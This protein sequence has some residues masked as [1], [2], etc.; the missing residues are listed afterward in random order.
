MLGDFNARIGRNYKSWNKVI[1]RH[2]VGKENR[3][4]TMLLDMC[5]RHK[6]TVTNTLFQQANRHKTSWM[7]PRSH[8][9]HLIDF[10]LVKQ[11]D[12]RDVRLT[13]AIRSTTIW[14][15]HRMIRTTA[16]LSAKPEARKHKAERV[17]K[18]DVGKLKGEDIRMQMQN[19]LD[20]AFATEDTSSWDQFKTT[21]LNTAKKVLGVKKITTQRLV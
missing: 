19:E 20:S 17:K 7:H 3:N 2:G 8:H 15:D 9:W 14:S 1:G 11:R 12:I 10:V 6:L 18:L 16:F 5:M 13:K 4:G 21:M